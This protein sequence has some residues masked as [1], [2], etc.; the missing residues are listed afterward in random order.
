MDK[1]PSTDQNP[2]RV[3]NSRSVCTR[4]MHFHPYEAKQPNLKLKS[5]SKQG[6]GK[7]EILGLSTLLNAGEQKKVFF[8]TPG[9][10]CTG[11]ARFSPFRSKMD[12]IAVAE[13][14]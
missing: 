1:L 2:G 10:S 4:A 3:F 13:H 9:K 11:S 14:L 12:D 5:Q 7:I 6:M 8:F